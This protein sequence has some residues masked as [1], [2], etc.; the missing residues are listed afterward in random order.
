VGA[1]AGSWWLQGRLP[2]DVYDLDEA[3]DGKAY[4]SAARYEGDGPH[5]V[6]V[7]MPNP[8]APS[9][10]QLI[11]VSPLYDAKGIAWKPSAPE[12]TSAV[13]LVACGKLLR[14]GESVKA[15]CFYGPGR[16][17]EEVVDIDRNDATYEINVY[18]LRTRRLVHT[19][20]VTGESH[21]KCP[22]SINEL[23]PPR[24]FSE[25][26]FAQWQSVLR[27]PVDKPQ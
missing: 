1:G 7:F 21:M 20:V 3:C 26:T 16:P 22:E 25:L 8:L 13:Q 11:K 17:K 24:L 6:A 19:S 2:D 12:T 23:R 5:P 18:E 15:A 27:G 10:E 9:S 4:R 14:A